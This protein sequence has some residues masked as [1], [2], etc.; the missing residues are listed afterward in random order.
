MSTAQLCRTRVNRC[1]IAAASSS[2]TSR[3]MAVACRATAEP[4]VVAP[5]TPAPR[6]GH[7]SMIR[8]LA[9]AVELDGKVQRYE[10]FAGRSAMVGVAAATVIELVTEQGVL[11]SV[12]AESVVTYIAATAAAVATA[13]GIAFF[14]SRSDN[15]T[16]LG[17]LELLEPVY[18]SLTAVRRSAASVTQAQ[19][20]RAVDYLYETVLERRF[21]SF[22]IEGLLAASDADEGEEL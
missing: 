6:R 17:G 22:S 8:S 20:D 15:V 4:I 9:A 10:T 2:K 7:S 11:G 12:T 21:D 3:K 16:D 14:R 18:A 5:T 19:V 13:I 1:S